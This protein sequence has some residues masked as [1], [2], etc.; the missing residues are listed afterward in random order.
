MVISLEEKRKHNEELEQ[1][2]EYQKIIPEVMKEIYTDYVE[3]RIETIKELPD[4]AEEKYFIGFDDMPYEPTPEERKMRSKAYIIAKVQELLSID[5]AQA[6]EYVSQLGSCHRLWAMQQN[7]LKERYGI[8]WYT[9]SELNP[10][11][12][13]D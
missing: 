2:P 7:I 11:I 5:P 6:A 1:S 13:F 9:P 8:T 10:D 4:E 3:S 12:V